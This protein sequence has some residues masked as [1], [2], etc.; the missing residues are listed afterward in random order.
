[1]C[2]FIDH[3]GEDKA[4]VPAIADRAGYLLPFDFD[5]VPDAIQEPDAAVRWLIGTT[6]PARGSIYTGCFLYL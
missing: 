5:A 3:N 6:L 1:M 4:E 2:S